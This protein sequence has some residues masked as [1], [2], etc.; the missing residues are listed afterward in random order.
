MYKKYNIHR[1]LITIILGSCF[2][3]GYKAIRSKKI[4]SINNSVLTQIVNIRFIKHPKVRELSK[5]K[6]LKVD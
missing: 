6:K 5:G 4:I 3:F 1:V 2:W